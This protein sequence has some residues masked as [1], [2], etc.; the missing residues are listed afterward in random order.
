M[1]NDTIAPRYRAHPT[2]QVLCWVLHWIPSTTCLWGRCCYYPH[3]IDDTSEAEETL[4]LGYTDSVSGRAEA[5]G[6]SY[7]KTWTFRSN[8]QIGCAWEARGE[9]ACSKWSFLDPSQTKWL[10][11]LAP[12][13]DDSD[14]HGPE[15]TLWETL[16]QALTPCLMHFLLNHIPVLF[17]QCPESY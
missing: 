9:W 13:P 3:F 16:L 11:I 1:N 17:A 8:S 7:S 10:R 2:C 4:T 14:V 12:F 6:L 5:R 15:T